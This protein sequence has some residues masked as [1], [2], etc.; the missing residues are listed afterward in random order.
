MLV[1]AS[2]AVAVVVGSVSPSLVL[3]QAAN[4]T[5]NSANTLKISPIRSDITIA[6]GKSG[7]VTVKVTN[8]SAAPMTVQAIENDFVAGDERGTPALILDAD[9]YAPTHSLKRYMVPIQ[10]I[11]IPANSKKNVKIRIDVPADAKPGGYFGAVRFQPVTAA[12][13]KS[14]NLDTSAASLILMTVSGDAVEKLEL[15]DF[16]VQQG[17]KSGAWFQ[18]PNDLQVTARFQNTGSVQEGPY[19]N[20]TVK[21]GDKVV[22]S[23]EFNTDQPRKM[24]LPDSARRWDVPLKNIGAFGNYTV[25]ATF[26]YGNKN[27][28]I[29]VTKSFWVI[30]MYVIIAAVAATLVLIGL[31]VGIWLFLRGY[32]RRI[33]RSNHRGGGGYRR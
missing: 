24:V 9:K 17:G 1:A 20:V 12:T 32:K 31:I 22:Y 10:N 28:S 5:V 26:T 7:I 15:T 14:V 30:P 23:Y 21:Q 18:S 3:A 33:L 27:E 2:M 16:Q 25:T 4:S 8:I 6:P 29:N 13:G 11:T 19:G